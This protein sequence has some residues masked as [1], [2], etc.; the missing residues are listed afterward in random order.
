M[1]YDQELKMKRNNVTWWAYMYEICA[2]SLLNNQ[3]RSSCHN[4]VAEK[5]KS[6][7]GL[8]FGFYAMQ[9]GP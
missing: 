1:Y 9:Y 7:N 8:P 3:S 5:D 6:V 4:M 2:N